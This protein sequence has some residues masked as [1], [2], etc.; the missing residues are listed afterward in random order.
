MSMNTTKRYMKGSCDNIKYKVEKEPEKYKY[1][2]LKNSNLK[3]SCNADLSNYGSS[4]S[5][6]S[7]QNKIKNFKDYSEKLE[8]KNY[9]FVMLPFQIKSPS[10]H[11]KK[12]FENLEN[13]R[14]IPFS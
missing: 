14:F 2:T 13:A 8:V 1:F 9:F 7:T 6:C 4:S 5:S 12:N 10:L 3:T 11:H